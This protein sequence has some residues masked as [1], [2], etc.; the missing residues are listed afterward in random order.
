M[1][2]VAK[3]RPL[4]WV[5]WGAIVQI[6]IG[7][8][9]ISS[10]VAGTVLWVAQS[11]GDERYILKGELKASIEALQDSLEQAQATRTRLN[12]E[13][14][15]LDLEDEVIAFEEDGEHRAAK[16]RCRKLTRNIRDWETLAAPQMWQTD[17]VVRNV[18][19]N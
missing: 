16:R 9:A 6:G 18:C 15:I 7:M 14:E 4:W 1:E 5:K 19:E 13:K 10:A 17:P 3:E 8:I 11:W 2:M 12:I